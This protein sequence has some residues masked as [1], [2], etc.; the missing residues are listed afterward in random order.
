MYSPV[1]YMGLTM[2]KKPGELCASVLTDFLQNSA[3]YALMAACLYHKSAAESS[4][5][6]FCFF[7]G[8]PLTLYIKT[9]ETVLLSSNS[10]L[11]NRT[12]FG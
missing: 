1:E 2:E 5:R 3:C 10:S 6:D 8:C 12:L 4:D 9:H 7:P 11:A